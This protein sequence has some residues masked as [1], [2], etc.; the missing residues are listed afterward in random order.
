MNRRHASPL[1]YKGTRGAK[2]TH[3]HTLPSAAGKVCAVHNTS[4][5]KNTNTLSMT[6]TPKQHTN[7]LRLCCAINGKHHRATAAAEQQT[8]YKHHVGLEARHKL[9]PVVL[10]LPHRLWRAR[11]LPSINLRQHS[12]TSNTPCQRW[13]HDI[14]AT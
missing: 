14:D 2:D 12:P 4:K 7:R 9:R 13:S 8:A 3:H 5:F 11:H 1:A 10:C 6:R